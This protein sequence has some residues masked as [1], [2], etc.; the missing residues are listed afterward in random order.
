M[1]PI[2]E[3]AG[4]ITITRSD[5]DGGRVHPDAGAASDAGLLSIDGGSLDRV[6]AR[7]GA[8]TEEE[9]AMVG[10]STRR[11]RFKSAMRQASPGAAASA[12]EVGMVL[13]QRQHSGS[14][15]LVQV[16]EPTSA[17]AAE[18]AEEGRFRWISGSDNNNAV[19]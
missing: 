11:Q 4:G 7:N 14:P 13:M 10:S 18:Q 12:R 6:D 9:E 16:V 5:G 15:R 2:E 17:L 1:P 3:S 19:E 8:L